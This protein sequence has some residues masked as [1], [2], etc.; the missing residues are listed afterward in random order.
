MRSELETHGDDRRDNMTLPLVLLRTAVV[1]A[2]AA[3]AVGFWRLQVVQHD[4]YHQLAEN[5]H[6]RTLGLRA[7]RGMV[8]DRDGRVLVENRNSLNISL[9]REQVD[10]LDS[11]IALLSEVAGVPGAALQSVV[12]RSRRAPAYQ[13]I[14]LIRDAT[15]GQVSAVAAHALEMP[16]LFVQELPAR[17]YPAAEV[18]AHLFGYVGEVSDAQ[19]ASAEFD[20]V[21]S[22][23]V[24]GKSGIESTY[25]A[26]LMGKDGARQVVVDAIGREVDTM[27]ETAP[28]EGR[29]LKLTL[30]YDLQEAAEAAFKVA[31]FDGAAVVL[32]P[33]SGEILSL[34]SLPAYDP[35]AF[36]MG[37]DSATWTGLNDDTRRP[38]NNRALQGR[39]SPGSTFKIA[40]AVAA[41]EEGVVDADER[42]TCNGGGT[43]YGRFYQC[44][45]THGSVD[46]REALERSCNTYFY[47]LGQK[48]EVDQIHKWATALGLGVMSGIDLPHEVQGLVPSTAW[49]REARGEPWYPGETISV[50]IGQGAVGVTPLSLA[51]MMATVVN[52][53]TRVTPHL[54]KAVNDGDGWVPAQ[55]PGIRSQVQLLPETLRVVTD[56]L[57]R[58]VNGQGTGGRGRIE[59]RDVIGK[60]GTA[61]V[62]SLNG[63]AAIGETDPEFFDHGWFVFAAPAHAPEIAGVVFG[64]HNEHGSLS[65]PIAKHVME[66]YFAKQEG[67]PLPVLPLPATPQ[68]VPLVTAVAATGN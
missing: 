31:G 22:G 29:Q 41:L 54:L 21:R 50:A 15:I 51:V 37:I 46:M 20:G 23:A 13:P 16:G 33:R 64:E 58:V 27:G 12:D 63:R 19:L 3:L 10:D 24:V 40:M 18:A 14:V 8:F 9:V 45:G 56:G 60:T 11:T 32:D 44:W 2:F 7:R 25:N 26:L 28:A 30:D 35:N 4:K 34:V 57:W 61:Q 68:A 47:T 17:Y 53:G 52:G 62:I 42:V 55:P 66:T 38:L 43:F 67:R 1:L 65:A 48:M 49:K 36:A 59:G 5:N 39:Y 6:Q